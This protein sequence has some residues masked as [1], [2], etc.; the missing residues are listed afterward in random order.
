MAME[1]SREPRSKRP[2][3]I[4]LIGPEFDSTSSEPANRTLIICAAPRTG[5]YELCRYL[6]AAGIGVPHEYFHFNYSRLL[7]ERWTI[8]GDPLQEA[9]LGRYMELL[10]CRRAQNG[11]FATKLQYAQFEQYLRNRHGASLFDGACV[12][13]LFRPDVAAQYASYRAA[14]ASGVW[15][16]SQRQTSEPI[17]RDPT[18][19]DKFFAD[20]LGE[21]SAIISADAGFRG[22]FIL[23]GIRPIFVTTDE[24][25]AEP[26]KVIRHIAN[27]TGSIVNE[28]SLERAIAC[29]DVY[30]H[31]RTYESAV[32]GLPEHFKKFAFGQLRI[33]NRRG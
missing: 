9:Q 19:F 16:F 7:G 12:V 30:D 33:V 28:K 32:S 27:A 15:D 17:L 2:D 3:T 22:L 13:H 1:T 25:F 14:M 31:H 29:S 10:R 21:F 11:V 18:N 6:L 26:Q 23:L 20:A 8:T 24:L 5:S 4:D